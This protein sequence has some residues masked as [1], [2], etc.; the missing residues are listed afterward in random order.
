MIA[1]AFVLDSC[2]LLQGHVLHFF[3]FGQIIIPSFPYVR[4]R[5]RILIE[6]LTYFLFPGEGEYSNSAIIKLN[7]LVLHIHMKLIN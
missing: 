2:Q 1:M 5:Y 7:T 4:M 6:S 3:C